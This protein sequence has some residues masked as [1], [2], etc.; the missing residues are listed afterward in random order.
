IPFKNISRVK[1]SACSVKIKNYENNTLLEIHKE[2]FKNINLSEL[3]EYIVDLL[4]GRQEVDKMKYSSVKFTGCRFFERKTRGS[5][6]R[7]SPI[8][9]FVKRKNTPPT[10]KSLFFD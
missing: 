10:Q 6:T 1:T 5:K 8:K 2:H 4:S 9:G 7:G 3:S